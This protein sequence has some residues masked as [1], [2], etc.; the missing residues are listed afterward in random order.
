VLVVALCV[1][2]FSLGFWARGGGPARA[3]TGLRALATRP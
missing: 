1:A 2:C 3:W